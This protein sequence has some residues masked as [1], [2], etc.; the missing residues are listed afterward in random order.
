MQQYT[1]EWAKE[2]LEQIHK[3]WKYMCQNADGSVNAYKIKPKLNKK[4]MIWENGL[5][6]YYRTLIGKMPEHPD[7]WENSLV[8]RE[9]L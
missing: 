6:I 3:A 7:G 1:T 4:L 2:Y 9:D 8:T 5:S